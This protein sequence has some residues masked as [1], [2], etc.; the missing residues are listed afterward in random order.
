[1]NFGA[2]QIHIIN[3][4]A[5]CNRKVP[6]FWPCLPAIKPLHKY[7]EIGHKTQKVTVTGSPE[8]SSSHVDT[9]VLKSFYSVNTKIENRNITRIGVV[10]STC[11]LYSNGSTKILK[12]EFEID[13]INVGRVDTDDEMS[14]ITEIEVLFWLHTIVLFY[15]HPT[16]WTDRR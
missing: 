11:A 3:Y 14:R 5:L 7:V 16:K 10:E 13:S 2:I 15:Y 4:A 8:H 6:V 1:M 9:D 12:M